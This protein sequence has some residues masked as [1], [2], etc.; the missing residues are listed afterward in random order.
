LPLARA[1]GAA[2][3]GDLPIGL[4]ADPVAFTGHEPRLRLNAATMAILPAAVCMAPL[5]AGSRTDR[6]SVRR[7]AAAGRVAVI[8]ATT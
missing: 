7:E 6:S 1:G 3:D 2:A 8:S 4:Q 5:H